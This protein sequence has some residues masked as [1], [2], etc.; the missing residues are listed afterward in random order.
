MGRFSLC[1]RKLQFSFAAIARMNLSPCTLSGPLKPDYLPMG[2]YR[3]AIAKA[4]RISN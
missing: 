4:Y 1:D 2:L 3:N